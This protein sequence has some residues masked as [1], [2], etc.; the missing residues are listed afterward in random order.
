MSE[1][2][3]RDIQRELQTLLRSAGLTLAVDV[4]GSAVTVSGLVLNDEERQ[5]AL[6]LAGMIPGVTTVSEELELVELM[7]DSPDAMFGD[8]AVDDLTNDPMRASADGIPYFPPTDPPVEG[9]EG[10]DSA[11]VAD[12]FLSTAMSDDEELDERDESDDEYRNDDA[13]LVDRVVLELAEDAMT[14]HMNL[15]V[16]ALG[17]IVVLSGIVGDDYDSEAAVAVAERVEGVAQVIDRTALRLET[18]PAM[19]AGVSRELPLRPARTTPSSAAWRATVIS[20]SFRLQAQRDQ[21][22]EQIEFLQ[23]DLKSYGVEQALEGRAPS[24]NADL[25]TDMSQAETIVAELGL[26]QGEQNEVQDALTRMGEGRYGICENCG[27]PIDR[28]RLKALPLARY[29][30]RCQRLIEARG[31]L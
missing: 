17:G 7:A 11:R 14:S 13:E 10:R 3:S 26:L 1:R 5:A 25:G 30:L 19:A 9:G 29:D 22:E 31:D 23:R 4:D 21:L 2:A 12:G 6:D 16:S 8:E 27:R 18:T 15:Y 24:H 20:N 28:A